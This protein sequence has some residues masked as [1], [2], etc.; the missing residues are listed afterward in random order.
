MPTLFM[1]NRIAIK[2]NA[3]ITIDGDTMTA[4]VIRLGVPVFAINLIT[5]EQRAV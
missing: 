1:L 2:V 3:D 4:Y 5:G